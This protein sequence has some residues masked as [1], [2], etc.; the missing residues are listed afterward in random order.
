MEI[1]DYVK[2]TGDK[3][4]KI[5]K[6]EENYSP[7]SVTCFLLPNFKIFDLFRLA[8]LNQFH[9]KGHK[10]ILILNESLEKKDNLLFIRLLNKMVPTNKKII[11]YKDLLQNLEKDPE[12]KDLLFKYRIKDFL[13]H[14]NSASSKEFSLLNLNYFLNQYFI[15]NYS[16]KF[17]GEKPDLVLSSYKKDLFFKNMPAIKGKKL[18]WIISLKDIPLNWSLNTDLKILEKEILIDNYSKEDLMEYSKMIGPLSKALGI[19]D[20]K[21]LEFLKLISKIKKEIFE[22]QERGEY[23]VPKSKFK[24]IIFALN[25]P[26][27]R[28]IISL[29]NENPGIKAGKLKRKINSFQPKNYS[30]ANVL[31]Q[32]EILSNSKIIE[33]KDNRTYQINIEK[34]ILNLPVSWFKDE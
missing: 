11:F 34:I 24:E 15:L 26:L 7:L 29:I 3:L 14:S 27:R 31:K 2:S 5:K 33:K 6:L 9:K 12:H 25:H 4:K 10:L 21:D 20:F 19:K 16:K 17:L 8:K 18:P 32:L 22:L 13:K 23:F 1:L 30:L 28:K